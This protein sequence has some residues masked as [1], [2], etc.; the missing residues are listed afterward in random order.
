MVQIGDFGGLNLR[1]P[2]IRSIRNPLDKSTVVSIF[3]KYIGE[4]K[5]T[6]HPGKF[7]IQPGTYENPALLVVGPSSWYREFPDDQPTLEIPCSSVEVADSIIRDYCNGM[8]G[9][10]MES[11]IPGMFFV[12]GEV[13]VIKIKTEYKNKLDEV[14][15]KQDNWY[16]NLVKLADSLW[17]RSNGNPLVIWDE[18]RLAAR[19]LNYNDKDWLKDFQIDELIRCI[20]CGSLKNPKYPVCPTC[21]AVD[22]NHPMAKEVKFAS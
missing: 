18:M 21:K 20:A 2:R 4:E 3:P 8:L 17:A 13:N 19:S 1:K 15:E 14:K 10:D 5:W 22:Q 9:C 11:A 6:I 12:P 7:I 16:R